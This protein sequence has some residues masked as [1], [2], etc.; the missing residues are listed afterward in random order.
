M[1]ERLLGER[2]QLHPDPG[3]VCVWRQRE[4]RPLERRA[5]PDGGQQVLDEREVQHLLLGDVDDLAPP[6]P[7]GRELLRRQPLVV[8]V[9]H[10]EGRVQVLAHH[11]L[12]ECRGLAE[13]PDQRLAVLE[14]HRRRVGNGATA[15]GQEAHQPTPW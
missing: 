8:A 1:P 11:E 2:Q 10:G 12:F 9:L 3:R 4:V 15:S 13:R 6:A 5:S 14:D 7:R